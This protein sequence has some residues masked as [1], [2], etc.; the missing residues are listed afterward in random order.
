MSKEYLLNCENKRYTVHPIKEKEMFQMYKTAMAAYWT[1]EEIDFSNDYEDFKKLNDDAQYFIKMILAFFAA[2]DGLVNENLMERFTN[3]VQVM[4]AL[5][6]YGFQVMMENVHGETYSLM[7]DNVTR[8]KDEKDKLLNA[9]ENFDCIKQKALWMKKW[10]NSDSPFVQRVIAFACVEGIF[11]SGSFAAIFWL[12]KQ[13]VMPGLC[14]SN[15]LI[16]RDE[17]MHTEFACLIKQKCSTILEK[18]TVHEI[19][20][21]AV[22]I[23]KGFM[24]ESLPCAMIGMNQEKMSEYIEYV[25]DRLLVMLNYEKIWNTKN[26]FDFMESIS[27]QGKT[28]FFES[29]PTQYQKAAV[30]NTGRENVFE[31]DDDF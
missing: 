29:R 1:P 19:I 15:E 24:C 9:I 20:K 8:D 21:E 27:M 30:L 7:L 12:K 23:E 4:E 2:S 11:F 18:E 26:P 31:V 28:N 16:A 10:M 3:E 22:E 13:N 17:G 25:A 5:M 6:F 14:D